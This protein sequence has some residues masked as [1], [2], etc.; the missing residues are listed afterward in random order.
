MKR[1]VAKGMILAAIACGTV[2]VSTGTAA[3]DATDP[4]LAAIYTPNPNTATLDALPK[5]PKLLAILAWVRR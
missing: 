5:H 4:T 3:A 2:A 1:T